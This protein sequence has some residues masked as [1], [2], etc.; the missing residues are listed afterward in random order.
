MKTSRNYD[1][2]G[3]LLA[4]SLSVEWGRCKGARDSTVRK[5]HA[6]L[7]QHSHKHRN[8]PHFEDLQD[9]IV[10]LAFAH[11][12]N[13]YSICV[14]VVKQ[15]YV[16]SVCQGCLLFLVPMT[17]FFLLMDYSSPNLFPNSAAWLEIC[18]QLPYS[19]I[20][21]YD[22]PSSCHWNK[23]SIRDIFNFPVISLPL[24]SHLPSIWKMHEVCWAS[25]AFL[26]TF[27]N[28]LDKTNTPVEGA[29]T[30]QKKPGSLEQSWLPWC[31]CLSLVVF[32][33]IV[34]RLYYLRHCIFSF[35]YST[36]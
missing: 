36:I 10:V 5:V 34:N 20:W 28:K 27:Q 3:P 8:N 25:F 1:L 2:K 31:I 21:P 22:W 18:F 30:Q 32:K 15:P 35:L 6:W 11:I 16:F 17:I 14:L 23:Q 24:L 29:E 19:L 9:F 12:C 4:N 13:S 7:C 26:F 33:K